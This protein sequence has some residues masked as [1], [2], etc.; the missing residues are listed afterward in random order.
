MTKI[1]DDKKKHPLSG[2]KV[3]FPEEDKDV[4]LADDELVEVGD[5]AG[6]GCSPGGKMPHAN[7]EA[8]IARVMDEDGNFIGKRKITRWI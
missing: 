6:K 3:M 5:M 4:P 7:F 2:R 8:T 1:E